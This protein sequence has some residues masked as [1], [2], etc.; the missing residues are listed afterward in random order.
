MLINTCRISDWHKSM[1]LI[2]TVYFF[3]SVRKGMHITKAVVVHLLL[4][5]TD[6]TRNHT[7]YNNLNAWVWKCDA[8]CA[9]Y[10]KVSHKPVWEVKSVHLNPAKGYTAV[11]SKPLCSIKQSMQ[12]NELLSENI[13]ITFLMSYIFKN[14]SSIYK[15]VNKPYLRNGETATPSIYN[16]SIIVPALLNFFSWLACL[17]VYLFVLLSPISFS[18]PFLWHVIPIA[19]PSPKLSSICSKFNRLLNL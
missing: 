7:D 15:K 19:P 17:T 9:L 1:L 5:R 4:N 13:H 10:L 3:A 6:R 12:L 11:F 14:K 8:F 16:S 18:L 2:S